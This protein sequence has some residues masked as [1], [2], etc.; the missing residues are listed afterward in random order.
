MTRGRGDAETRGQ[1]NTRGGDTGTRGRG[2]GVWISDRCAGSRR[3]DPLCAKLRV[4]KGLGENRG[5][6]CA[7]SRRL[8]ITR[9]VSGV[10]GAQAERS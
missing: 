5:R 10:T 2:E 3:G 6:R 7:G 9:S 4:G 1:K 8:W